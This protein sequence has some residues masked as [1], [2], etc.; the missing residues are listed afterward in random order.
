M[1]IARTRFERVIARVRSRYGQIVW[2][3][4]FLL[5]FGLRYIA[6]MA[7]RSIS[8]VRCLRPTQSLPHAASR[9]TCARRRQFQMQLG[10]APH[11]F[12]IA[13][14]DRLALVVPSRG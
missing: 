6:V 10:D 12:E 3:E 1:S 7:V 11:Q 9:A 8:V 4:A 13:I 14:A 5:L 2:P